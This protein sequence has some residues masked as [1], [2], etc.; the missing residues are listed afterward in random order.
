[1]HEIFE[2]QNFVYLI[3]DF[4]QTGTLNELIAKNK[5]ALKE[6]AALT[7]LEQVLLILDYTHKRCITLNQITLNNILI[8]NIYHETEEFEVLIH[9]L[10]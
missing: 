5:G 4:H 7:I 3:M 6:E 9:G 2:D 1:M 10:D 8:K